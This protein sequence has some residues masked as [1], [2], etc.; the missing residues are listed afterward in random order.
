MKFISLLIAVVFCIIPIMET[1]PNYG[2]DIPD[3]WAVAPSD[4]SLN[5]PYSEQFPSDFAEWLATAGEGEVFWGKGLRRAEAYE[6]LGLRPEGLSAEQVLLSPSKSMLGFKMMTKRL[7]T[8]F[9]QVRSRIAKGLS[10][11]KKPF[12]DTKEDS[13]QLKEEGKL[14]DWLAKERVASSF[15][16]DLLGGRLELNGIQVSYLLKG[17]VAVRFFDQPD[18]KRTIDKAIMESG[19]Y[20]VVDIAPSQIYGYSRAFKDALGDVLPS[21]SKKVVSAR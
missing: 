16:S 13:V 19:G 15:E 20:K 12:E 21:R 10:K 9:A 18:S 7:S 14:G 2:L 5:I 4:V 6:A 11:A 1:D 8:S 3:S 17:D